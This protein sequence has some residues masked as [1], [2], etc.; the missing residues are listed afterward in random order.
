VIFCL[1]DFLN[2]QDQQSYLLNDE[3]EEM[4]DAVNQDAI[5][6]DLPF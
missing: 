2:Y 5:E 3:F 6:Q 4:Q 1:G